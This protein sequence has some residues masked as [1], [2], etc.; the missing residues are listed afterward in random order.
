MIIGHMFFLCSFSNS[1]FQKN[2]KISNDNKSNNNLKV[3]RV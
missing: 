2:Y 1:D 3:R